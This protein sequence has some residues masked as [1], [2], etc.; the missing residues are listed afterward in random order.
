MDPYLAAE[1]I[2]RLRRVRFLYTL[3]ALQGSVLFFSCVELVQKYCRET[4]LYHNFFTDSV[5]ASIFSYTAI[6]HSLKQSWAVFRPVYLQTSN[7]G[8]PVGS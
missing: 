8:K 6:R 2:Y 1:N 7:I 5:L 3:K 4:N